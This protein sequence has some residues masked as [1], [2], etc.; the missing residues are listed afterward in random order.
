MQHTE[1]IRWL[2]SLEIRAYKRTQARSFHHHTEMRLTIALVVTIASL[3][4]CGAPIHS[5]S[6]SGCTKPV[7]EPP[8][9]P[10]SQDIHNALV[11]LEP[12][13]FKSII[14]SIPNLKGIILQ[15]DPNHLKTALAGI[16][17]I[18]NLINDLSAD[19]IQS[20]VR[21]VKD[22]NKL[23]KGINAHKL[24][25]LFLR[26]PSTKSFIDGLDASVIQSI[27]DESKQQP[28]GSR[29]PKWLL[30]YV[31]PR[32]IQEIFYTMPQ[33]RPE[34]A[35][36]LHQ[37]DVGFVESTASGN[38]NLA[39]PLVHMQP[40]TLDYVLQYVPST[41]RKIA[42]PRAEDL[43]IVVRQPPDIGAFL[44]RVDSEVLEQIL[45]KVPALNGLLPIPKSKPTPEPKPVYWT[46][47]S[48]SSSSSLFT[49][50]E[51]KKIRVIFP[52]VDELLSIIS[53]EKQ[54]ELRSL[55]P[56][57]ATAIMKLEYDD[58]TILNAN[59]TRIADQLNSLTVESLV[60]ILID[61]RD[62][63][64]LRKILLFPP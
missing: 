31:D 47:K 32:A 28:R 9:A 16:P 19:E 34:L 17:G 62:D 14:I 7:S 58:L 3:L 30:S 46:Q 11:S 36:S 24:K 50:K 61:E 21:K 63:N 15:L 12:E 60:D 8:A 53:T 38:K 43:E 35:D 49:K 45:S 40:H 59:V 44:K 27:M 52:R 55:F 18:G 37:L 25:F 48:R 54:E 39:S 2:V 22:I 5:G 56:D 51:L 57:I 1:L 41:D 29:N 33:I 26:L 10:S 6:S 20:S 64:V 4:V 13:K 23:L 42:Q